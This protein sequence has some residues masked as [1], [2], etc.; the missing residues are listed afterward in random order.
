MS[1]FHLLSSSLRDF[2]ISLAL[3]IATLAVYSQVRDFDFTNYDDPDYVTENQHVRQGLSAGGLAWAFTSAFAANW[4]PLTWLSHMLDV[5]LF[6]L[7]SG[8]HH[9]TNVVLHAIGAV[10][11]FALFNRMTGDRWRSAFVAFVFALHP[12]HVESVAWIAER[13]D[14]LCAL[15]WFLTLLAYVRYTERPTVGRY[16]LVLAAFCCG[17]MSKPMIVTLPFVALLLDYWPL[18]RIPKMAKK[19]AL[20]KLP[21]LGLSAIA[22]VVTYLVQQRGGAVLSSDHISLQLRIANVAISYFVYILK[23]F[24]PANLAVFYP[25]PSSF[26][27]WQIVPAAIILVGVTGLVLAAKR[28]RPYLAVGWLWYLGT[29]VPVIGLVQV[30]LQ[31]RAD[32]Y[33]Y[34]P[35]I[36]ISIM[37]AWAVPKQSALLVA[38]ASACAAMFVVTWLNVQHWRNSTTLF[39]H[40][41]DVTNDNYVAHNNLGLA[42]RQQGHPDQA[43]EHFERAL[44][45]RPVFSEAQNNLGDALLSKGRPDDALPHIHEA[46]RL[47]PDSAAAHVN[48]GTALLKRGD[49]GAAVDQYRIAIKLQP[50]DAGAHAGL[51]IALTEIGNYPDALSEL[52]GALRLKPEDANARYNFGRLLGLM[53]RTDEAIVQLTETIR[54]QPDNAE[55]HFNLG[56]ALAAQDKLNQA[57]GEFRIAVRLKPDYARA[58]FNLGSA[59][60]NLGRLDEAIREFSEVLRID[61]SSKAARESLDYCR[62]LQGRH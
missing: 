4:F 47:Q 38:A 21:L 11:L 2:W 58:H 34:I 29:L 16:A 13:K 55:A 45:I 33:T 36:G 37:L 15:F 61:P 17:L 48:L 54:L 56:T 9:L 42:L 62:E 20:E 30:G 43:I 1:P 41:I 57:A 60:A 27:V 50:D 18:G 24:R 10:L 6:G 32:R 49:A 31:S 7:Q 14:V 53:G 28:R 8:F 5:Q 44:A 3:L 51:G 19:A 39:Q 26:P 59:L 40:A 22:S 35:L 12:L 46:L 23:F 25:Y 52:T